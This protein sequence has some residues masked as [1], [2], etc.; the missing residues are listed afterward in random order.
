MGG[1]VAPAAGSPSS[2]SPQAAS[3]VAGGGEREAQGKGPGDELAPREPAVAETPG[4]VE[5]GV[6]ATHGSPFVRCVAAPAGG[7]PRSG[8]DRREKGDALPSII[9][10][11]GV[12]CL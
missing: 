2:E 6:V 4:E 5:D 12:A 1:R 11:E 10:R 3:T 8:R 9:G 7:A